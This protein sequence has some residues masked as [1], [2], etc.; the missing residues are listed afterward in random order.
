MQNRDRLSMLFRLRIVLS[1]RMCGHDVLQKG[2]Q[3]S[4]SAFFYQGMG[5][6]Q[7][8]LEFESGVQGRCGRQ[9]SMQEEAKQTSRPS[10]QQCPSRTS[11][12]QITALI[13]MYF[14]WERRQDEYGCKDM[15]SRQVAVWT[16]TL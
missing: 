11:P 9:V 12:R 8:P 4:R 2:E 14:T 16:C 6:G 15:N 10:N 3:R 13:H 5:K 1:L 7:T